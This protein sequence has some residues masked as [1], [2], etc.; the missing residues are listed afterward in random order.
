MG[1]VK[2]R[3]V[4]RVRQQFQMPRIPEVELFPKFNFSDIK[5]WL[6]DEVDFLD[7]NASFI[8]LCVAGFLGT[9]TAIALGVLLSSW[10]ILN[11]LCCSLLLAIYLLALYVRSYGPH[12]PASKPKV[13]SYKILRRSRRRPLE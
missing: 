1:R 12:S 7:K 6:K 3:R 10:E 5:R 8:I 13:N 11:P 4:V 2:V 9:A